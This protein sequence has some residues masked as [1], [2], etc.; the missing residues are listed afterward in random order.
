MS[1]SV[2]S[3]LSTIRSL[4]SNISLI[5]PTISFQLSDISLSTPKTLVSVR[6]CSQGVLGRW[7]QLWGRS[8]IE[9]VWEFDQQSHHKEGGGI[10]AR[11]FV[12]LSASHGKRNQFIC[13]FHFSFLTLSSLL[14]HWLT[15][16]LFHQLLIPN[17]S[18]LIRPYINPST[19]S[20]RALR[21]LDT[22]P[23]SS[24]SLPPTHLQTTT[25]D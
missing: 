15:H 19:Y 8:G 1:T 10:E 5:H 16:I 18:P 14:F 20:S 12:S 2:S 25:R 24:P 23:L 3:T 9:R 21:S 4:V 22:P 7:R 17:P 6:N 11:G 13:T